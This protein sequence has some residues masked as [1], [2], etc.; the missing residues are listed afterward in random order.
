[1]LWAGSS[2]NWQAVESGVLV[3][4]VASGRAGLGTHITPHYDKAWGKTGCTGPVYLGGGEV[5]QIC[6]QE[7]A[8]VPGRDGN[9][10]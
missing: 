5:Q 9:N 1:M 7:T 3:G 4:T 8:K 6:G 10:Y 2:Q